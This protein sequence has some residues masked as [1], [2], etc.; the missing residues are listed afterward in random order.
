MPSIKTN[1]PSQNILTI[2]WTVFTHKATWRID[3]IWWCRRVLH[4]VNVLEIEVESDHFE[5][6][7]D[8]ELVAFTF[9]LTMRI[10]FHFNVFG[11]LYSNSVNI[12]HVHY[13]SILCL[14]FVFAVVTGVSELRYFIKVLLFN[15]VG[16]KLICVLNRLFYY[17]R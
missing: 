16:M 9:E 2:N 17:L 6:S 7:L 12:W 14:E 11:P 8:I 5:K 10:I 4:L 3:L 1:E 13:V 15:S